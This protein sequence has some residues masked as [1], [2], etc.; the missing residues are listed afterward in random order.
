MISESE[1]NRHIDETL[2][3]IEEAI[4]ESGADI[5]YENVSGILTLTFEDGSQII[6]NR[7][8]PARQ[9]WVA[10]KTG[11]YHFDFDPAV[12]DWFRDRDR[13]PLFE[14]LSAL[15]SDQAGESVA[16]SAE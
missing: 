7:Q 10:A 13:A 12:G 16:L 11:G 1:F 8:T 4:D 14:V 6:I 3:K 2:L 5:E 15:A 9:L